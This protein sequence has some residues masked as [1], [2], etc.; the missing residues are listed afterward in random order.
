MDSKTLS[1]NLVGLYPHQIEAVR[2]LSNGK[3]LWG[4]VGSGKSRVAIAYYMEREAPRDVYILTTAKKRD[5][6]DWEG[7]AVRYGVYKSKDATVAGVL[8]VDSWN[9]IKKY[10]EVK[11]GFFIF[12]EQRLVG[13]GAWVRSFLKIAKSNRWI[14]L[15]ATPG[16]T[17]TDYIPVFVA[18]RYYK[19]RTQ[20]I[21]EHV[22]YNNFSKYPKIDRFIGT[23]KLNKIR[24]ELLVHMPYSSHLEPVN[25]TVEVHYD[26]ERYD[27][28]W[29]KRWN[30]YEEQPIENVSQL[31]YILRRTINDDK[32]RFFA[33]RNLLEAHSKLIVF[34]N[35]DYELDILRNLSEDVPLG[36]WNGHKH[37]P[38]PDTDR[39]VYLVQYTSGAEGWNC[40]DTN[41]V[42]FYSMNY[43]HRLYTQAKGR[44]DRMDSSW[45][46]VWYY[47][48]MSDAPLD[49]AIR[50]AVD[51]KK[52]FNE[53]SFKG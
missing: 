11:D 53:A 18:N 8:T 40:T 3:I 9:N 15:S 48:L 7:E 26:K 49:K 16:D 41:A 23:G 33:V 1:P 42:C 19:N 21:R 13:S 2:E 25:Q 37:Q 10:E 38:I 45:G 14:L 4:G 47:T 32:S 29:R 6:L 36:E 24:R 22:V 34:Y 39:W 50:A 12:D 31:F 20:F 51:V 5:S 43:S 46:E 27:L 44:I 52:I 30:P 35:F 17:W 28:V